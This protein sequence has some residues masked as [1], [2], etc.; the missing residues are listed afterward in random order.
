[1]LGHMI[2]NLGVV[3]LIFIAAALKLQKLFRS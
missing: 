3:K 2:K 1:M